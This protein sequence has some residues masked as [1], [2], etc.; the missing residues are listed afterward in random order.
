MTEEE[1]DE[2]PSYR[3]TAL[4]ENIGPYR[5]DGVL[6]GGGMGLVYRGTAPD[7][8]PVAVKVLRASRM[9]DGIVRRFEREARIRIE[10]ENVVA[11]LDAGVDTD[12]TPFI[13]FERLEGESLQQR[14]RRGPM[15]PREAVDFAVQ[16][17]RGLVAAHDA[18][19]IHRDLK[20]GNLFICKDGTVK[21]LDFGIARRTR[22][23]TILTTTAGVLGTPAYLSPEQ[24][25]G[26][27]GV[28]HRSDV[29]ALGVVLY[30]CL[31]NYRPFGRESTVATMLAIVLDDPPPLST[32]VAHLPTALLD[33]V[34][35]C[36]AKAKS[37]R[38]ATMN[39]LVGALEGLQLD[40]SE[41]D[42]DLAAVHGLPDAEDDDKTEAHAPGTIEV[43]EQRLVALLFA[44]GVKALDVIER[45]VADHG[46]VLVPLLGQRAIGIFGNKAWE[47]DEVL[48]ATHAAMRA[49]EASTWMA[50]AS[51]RA[52]RSGGGISGEVVRAAE[53]AVAA[54]TEGVAVPDEVARQLR[55]HFALRNVRGTLY[56]VTGQVTADRSIAPESAR[57]EPVIGREVELLQIQRVLNRVANEE[58]VQGV[59]VTGA[60]G[61]GK[62]RLRRELDP[63]LD[64]T[65]SSFTIL[66]GRGETLRTQRAFSLLASVLRARAAHGEQLFGW[67]SLAAK[68]DAAE[69]KK[70]V[71]ELAA[72]MLGE[73]AEQSAP[74]LGELLGVTMPDTPELLAARGDPQLMSDRIHIAM[75]DYLAG[76]CVKGPV[77]MLLEDLQWADSSSL[78]LLD[79]L[80]DR[81]SDLPLLVFGTARPELLEQ[82][83]DLFSGR[84]VTRIQL[85][86]LTSSEITTLAVR[87]AGKPLPMDL[88]IRL[89]KHT[90]GNPLFVEQI[91]ST[92]REEDRLSEAA[93]LPLPLTVEGALQSRLDKLP[94]EERE[95]CKRAAVFNRPCDALA[96]ETLGV[97]DAAKHVASLCQREL[98]TA[99][100]KS[101]TRRER[102][103]WFTTELFAE[104][105][106]RSL[107][108]GLRTELHRR[109]GGYLGTLPDVD[110][111]EV[112][113]HYERG[114][115][116]VQA[117]IRYAT[118]A[119]AASR[120]ADSR[121]VLRCSD[122][123]LELGASPTVEYSLRMARADA[124]RFLGRRPDQIKELEAALTCECTEV[125]R[126]RA[127]IEK[128][129]WTSRTGTATEALVA[130]DAAVE[131]ARAAGDGDVLA[132]AGVRQAAALAY[133][134]RAED[135]RRV[136]DEASAA[137][138]KPHTG[139][140]IW[141]WRG[142][143][144]A[145][146]GDLGARREAFQ[147]ASEL[148]DETGDPRRAA[149][150]AMNLADTYNR[151]GA[152]QEAEAALRD[153]L[154]RLRRVGNRPGEGYA[155]VNLGYSLGML[156]YRDEAIKVLTEARTIADS[157]QDPRLALA[158]R[159][160]LARAVL[161]RGSPQ[162][163][164]A[165]AVAAA[166]EAESRGVRGL[167][168]TALTL[169][170]RARLAAGDPKGAHEAA[171]RAMNL[172]DEL[173]TVEEDEAEV[174]LTYARTLDAIG[175]TT[176]ATHIIERGRQR[177]AQLADQIAD[178][179]WRE[180]FL[181][182]VVA[183]REL[184]GN[185]D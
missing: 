138:V 147:R 175:R 43:G 30:E 123:A 80:F 129:V 103:F 125:E 91:V 128:A 169:A 112:A 86:G 74:F 96:L 57:E 100:V 130:A 114:G 173:G 41:T 47:G 179:E 76:A 17:G 51:G 181:R 162:E 156:G 33:I 20:P 134:G 94:G 144:A 79:E 39:E 183:H 176:D 65:G 52:A 85:Q 154:E 97:A 119:I 50:V 172:R 8:R 117:G 127:L 113:V 132:L 56:E 142:Q 10:H 159:V 44:D 143:L 98:M 171:L 151:V 7:G 99:R 6:G 9:T 5:L 174:F 59:L 92:L 167:A 170:A 120:R 153:A 180:R 4:R 141:E 136:L 166:E 93:E 152:Y 1:Q 131:A 19:V 60:P 16:V 165:E 25:R 116:L 73:D 28:D 54:H 81:A 155:Q 67:P 77:A 64:E 109:V 40:D 13:V 3:P 37:K 108:E 118:A 101:K 102:E 46:G 115:E 105:S 38:W 133:A 84:E 70:A 68:A 182:H 140:L 168:V 27:A 78:D 88:L 75:L 185:R 178:P 55:T 36:L 111:E 61:I 32:R 126:A 177:L 71:E 45:A 49:R 124:L 110:P 11:V 18:G 23:E 164:A 161:D 58:R 63:M 66:S 148:Y 90:G 87:V 24:A 72:E 15:S 22:S 95:L 139:A 82:K 35:R 48:R 29:W 163:V 2:K 83:P 121:S 146:V 137:R 21:V 12:G 135:A 145:V 53:V 106:Y 158:A 14:L 69:Q 89:T 42:P 62:S 104:I 157:A 150:M 26:G 31:S 184:M 107:A 122:K 160:Y 149:A 34:D